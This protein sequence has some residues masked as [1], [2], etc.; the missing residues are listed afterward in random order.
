MTLKFLLVAGAALVSL[1]S[2]CSSGAEVD[3]AIIAARDLWRS[4]ELDDYEYD[5]TFVSFIEENRHTVRV[6]GG[7]VVSERVGPSE[8]NLTVDEM[9]DL[10]ERLE[11][12]E[13][14]DIAEA[15]FDPVT[16]VPTFINVDEDVAATDT[17]YF[18]EIEDF[19][20]D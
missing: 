18:W 16:G 20:S 13:D 19:R 6:E 5:I 9:F 14:A 15:S 12:D 1:T 4:Q 2:S 8:A 3:P 7:L 11:L 17:G 10:L